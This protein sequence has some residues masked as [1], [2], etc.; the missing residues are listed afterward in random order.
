MKGMKVSILVSTLDC[1][2]FSLIFLNVTKG[3]H[4]SKR[5]YKRVQ[6][7]LQHEKFAMLDETA[8]WTRLNQISSSI[9]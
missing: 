3:F 6:H 2:G 4:L 5:R 1:G 7:F 8:F 9:S